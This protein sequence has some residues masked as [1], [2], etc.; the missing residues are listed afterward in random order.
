MWS[1]LNVFVIFILLTAVR[2]HYR[3]VQN[4]IFYCYVDDIQMC[5]P[6]KQSNKDSLPPL[7]DCVDP[8]KETYS[9]KRY[10]ELTARHLNV[11]YSALMFCAI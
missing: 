6:L 10:V 9:I 3:E 2:I 5:L 4:V 11:F 1:H 8:F 7:L